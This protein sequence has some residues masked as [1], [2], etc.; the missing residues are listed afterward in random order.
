MCALI[1]RFPLKI[2]PFSEFLF[3]FAVS[4]RIDILDILACV[5]EPLV[6]AY[7]VLNT[8]SIKVIN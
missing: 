5:T 8:G 7:S 2:Y 3:T 1:H 4:A 6:G